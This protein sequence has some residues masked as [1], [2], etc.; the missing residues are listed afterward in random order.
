V[1]SELLTAKELAAALKMHPDT[2]REW[3]REGRIIPEFKIGRSPRFDLAK[4]RKALSKPAKKQPGM[5]PTR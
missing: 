4:V 5:I 3:A 2:V 1:T